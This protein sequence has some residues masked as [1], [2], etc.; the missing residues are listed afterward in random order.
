MSHTVSLIGR[1]RIER[2]VWEL[3]QRLWELPRRRRIDC[4][5]EVRQNLLA[6]AGE[7]GVTAAMRGVGSAAELARGY[8]AAEYG[9]R[10]RPHWWAAGIAA[11]LIAQ[12]PLLI[13]GQVTTMNEAAIRAV[14]PHATGNFTVPGIVFLQ[15]ATVYTF[16]NGQAA[17]SGGDLSPLFYIA[18]LASVILI[19]RLWRV[20][21]WRNQ[22]TA[23]E[24][25]SA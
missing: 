13:Q 20:R 15:H 4:R 9:D 7:T 11:L 23:A 18:W 21:I 16:S 1:L 22:V 14:D 5:R 24:S 8:K 3:D 25:S 12:L 19:G 10:P 6:A 17:L 2:L